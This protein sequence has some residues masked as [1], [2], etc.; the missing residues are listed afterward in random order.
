MWEKIKKSTAVIFIRTVCSPFT[1]CSLTVCSPFTQP[2]L[3][4]QLPITPHSLNIHSRSLPFAHRFQPFARR[5]LTVHS[6]F[7]QRSLNI[8]SSSLTIHSP[9]AHHSCGKVECFRDFISMIIQSVEI[10]NI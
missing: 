2:S 1:Y 4:V 3:T 8:H 10:Q 6:T 5:L 9:F 7:T